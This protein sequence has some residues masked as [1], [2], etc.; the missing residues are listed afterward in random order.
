MFFKFFIILFGNIIN[1]FSVFQ[2]PPCISKNYIRGF[3]EFT[4]Q[5]FFLQMIDAMQQ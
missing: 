4:V 1:G 3:H 2:W 5:R